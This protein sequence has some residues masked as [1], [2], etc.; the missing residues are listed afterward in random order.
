MAVVEQGQTGTGSANQSEQLRKAFEEGPTAFELLRNIRTRRVG[1]GYRID[2]G[3]TEKH[4][5]TGHE[6][7]QEKGPNAFVSRKKPIAISEVEEALLAW[8][9]CGPNGI[10]AWDISLDG[11]FHELVDLAGRTA[12]QPGNSMG[13][14]LLIINDNGAFIYN[15]GLNRE[16]TIEMAQ[17]GHQGRYDKVLDWY[18]SGCVQ[19][20]DERPDIDYMT[21]IPGVHNATLMGPY[22]YNINRPGTTWFIPIQDVGKLQSALIN[23]H[24]AWHMYMIDEWNGGRPA[25]VAEWVGEG[26]LEL[27]VPIAAE[28]QLIFQVEMYSAGIMVQNIKIACESLGLGHWNFCGFNPDILFGALPDLTRGLGFQIEPPNPKAPIST[29]QMKVFGI[30][31]AK[32]ATYVPSPQFPTAEALVEAWYQEKYGEGAWGDTGPNNLMRRGQGPWKDD[33]IDGIVNHPKARPAD[34]CKDATIAY[35]QYCVDNF[36]QWPVTYN[37][38]QAHFGVVVHHLDTDYYD[39]HYREGYINERHRNHL[40]NWHPGVQYEEE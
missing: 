21:R 34:W 26:K 23:F 7:S 17:N 15:P 29:G 10:A 18:R 3:T 20:L 8:A 37:P 2:S 13:S 32:T 11:G 39:E 24:D 6:M 1:L 12:S 27:P 4:P 40:Q 38:M 19:I 14:D 36:G 35:V 30:E 25:G 33:H 22:Q 31:G 16:A 28:E 5:V 9:C